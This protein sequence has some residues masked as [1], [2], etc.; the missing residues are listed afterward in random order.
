LTSTEAVSPEPPEPI[1]EGRLPAEAEEYG[2]A[3]VI[4]TGD[5]ATWTADAVRKEFDA[6]VAA[7]PSISSAELF[8]LVAQRVNTSVVRLRRTNEQETEP[9]KE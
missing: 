3:I 7:D 6:I 1:V 4:A 2:F 9:P 5:D 8:R